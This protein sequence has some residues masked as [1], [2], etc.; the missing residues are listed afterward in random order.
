MHMRQLNRACETE[1]DRE[2]EK[3][4]LR[5]P[6]VQVLSCLK[7]GARPASETSALIYGMDK[8]KIN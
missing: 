2:W 6:P 8:S 7:T 4:D 5:A 1:S 3:L